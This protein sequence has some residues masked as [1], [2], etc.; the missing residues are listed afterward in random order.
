MCTGFVY[1]KPIA[2]GKHAIK[3]CTN[4]KKK[5]E[6]DVNTMFQIATL[7]DPAELNRKPAGFVPPKEKEEEKE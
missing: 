7:I 1:D 6:M 4:F 5:G 3:N 2:I